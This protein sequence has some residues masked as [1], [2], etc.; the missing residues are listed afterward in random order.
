MSNKE[1]TEPTDHFLASEDVGTRDFPADLP[2]PV[3]NQQILLQ[4]YR[5]YYNHTAADQNP[6]SLDWRRYQ[7]NIHGPLS[8][9]ESVA[10]SAF[11][12]RCGPVRSASSANRGCSPISTVA[13]LSSARSAP[14]GSRR[15]TWG[16]GERERERGSVD[17]VFNLSIYA[18]YYLQA[19]FPARSCLQS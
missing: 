6:W 4:S 5:D 17:L 14:A 2:R 13:L 19:F 8:M 12:G 16:I 10:D 9:A 3:Y 11:S 15:G 1:E 7:Q 18:L